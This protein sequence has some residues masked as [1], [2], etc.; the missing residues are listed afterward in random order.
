MAVTL[1][2]TGAAS[3]DVAF[4]TNLPP[5]AVY[6]YLSDFQKHSEWTEELVTIEQTSEGSPCVGTTFRTTESMR[7]GSGMRNATCSEITALQRPRLIEWKAWTSTKGGPMAMRS[8][9]AFLIEPDG[10]GS[11]VTQRFG[12]DPPNVWSRIF[13]R[14]FFVVADGLLGGM[15]ASPKNITMHAEKLQHVLDVRSAVNNL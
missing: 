15:G 6:D 3:G 1:T 7:P 13:L 9:W 5:D 10:S 4:T 14:A 8:H 12:F 2:R 11:R